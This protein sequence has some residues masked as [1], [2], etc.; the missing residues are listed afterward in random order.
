LPEV[1]SLIR[2]EAERA[3]ELDPSDTD[4]Q[5]VIGMVAAIH[6]YSW[7]EAERRLQLALANPSA[8]AEAHW[9]RACVLSTFA[10]FEESS[11]EM[12]RAVE[13]DPLSVLWR[14]V[15]MAHL[16]CAG[17]YEEALQEGAKALD[18]AKDEIHPHLAMAEAYLALGRLEEAFAAAERAYRNLPQ[19]SMAIGFLAATLMRVGERN[20]AQALLREMGDSP[21]PLWGRAWYHLLCSEPDEAA[22]WYEAM[23]DEREIFAPV[24]ANSLYTAELRASAHWPRLARMM[25]LPATK[26]AAAD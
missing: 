18:V 19:H 26:S 24:Y 16:V 22:R 14:G 20:R 17:R 12:R 25:N 8:P 23:I 7:S 21:R 11:A 9:G 10:R 6:D 1:A 4:P 15:L 2:R 13:Q 5:Y 3:L